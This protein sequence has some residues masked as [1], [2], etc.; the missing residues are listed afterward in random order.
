MAN[1]CLYPNDQLLP[2]DIG[3]QVLLRRVNM[4]GDPKN[5][6]ALK[7]RENNLHNRALN[8]LHMYI[9]VQ[10]F[11]KLP[12]LHLHHTPDQLINY[13]LLLRLRIGERQ[14]FSCISLS[15]ILSICEILNPYLFSKEMFNTVFSW[16]LL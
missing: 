6:N 2:D 11:F 5:T 8:T 15:V 12:K 3:N 16:S 13:P 4:V 7:K 10:H 1:G 9:A 14:Y